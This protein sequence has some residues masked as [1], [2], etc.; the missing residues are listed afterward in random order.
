MTK[1]SD[2]ISFKQIII[3]ILISLSMIFGC[4]G[5]DWSFDLFGGDSVNGD[6]GNG[7]NNG[8]GDD[9]N[10]IGLFVLSIPE[11]GISDKFPAAVFSAITDDTKTKKPV[12]LF[13]SFDDGSDIRELTG[14]INRDGTGDVFK[15]S[16]D[17]KR[18]AYLS[19][20]KS[21]DDAV[22]RI[23]E[24]PSD[25]AEVTGFDW[26]PDSTRIAYLANREIDGRVELYTNLAEGGDNLKVS[27]GGTVKAFEWS[28]DSKLLAYTAD[29]NELGEFELFT[30]PPTERDPVRVSGSFLP[31]RG[32]VTEF[33][34]SPGSS[35]VAYLSDQQLAGIFEL[36][37]SRPRRSQ[38]PDQISN[39]VSVRSFAWAPD[40]EDEMIAYSTEARIF[41]ASPDGGSSSE[42]VTPDP[43]I[44]QEISDFSWAPNSSR[45]AYRANQRFENIIELFT[46]EPDGGDNLRISGDFDLTTGGDV[47]DFVWSPNSRFV[48]YRANQD[49]V[50]NFELY[51]T[52]PD[53]SSNDTKVTGTPM[54]G[55]VDPV[56][57][58]S[59]DSKRVAYLAD[60]RFAGTIELFTATPDGEEN[61]RISGDLASGGNVGEFIWAPDSSSIGYIADQETNNVFELFGSTPDGA[62]T[63]TLSGSLSEDGDVSFF[64]WV[65]DTNDE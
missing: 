25:D 5:D 37:T 9:D 2:I 31:N 23:S 3:L 54:I 17:G 64:E 29:R 46:V 15:V 24:L 42:Q 20:E 32:D 40:E 1:H 47:T 57:E 30:T 52:T 61:D 41:T 6:D 26:S 10:G 59:P 21:E 39:G 35:R 55:E 14:V 27:D 44:N 38:D 43:A 50:T 7:N 8:N 60:Q 19:E 65:P 11:D 36:F 51:V 49:N 22:I 48:A 62:E 56:F 58:W 53:D 28:P 18:V 45:I 63:V 12:E 33:S 16:P 4:N 13:S 34:W